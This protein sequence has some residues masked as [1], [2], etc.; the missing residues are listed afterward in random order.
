ML[1][2]LFY[3]VFGVLA[4]LVIV[5]L[6]LMV[7]SRQRHEISEDD[8]I[9]QELLNRVMSSGKTTIAMRDENGTV[10][11]EEFDDTDS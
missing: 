11:F 9:T 7:M 6:A 8:M 10:T 3:C 1:E 5:I 2:I 4:L